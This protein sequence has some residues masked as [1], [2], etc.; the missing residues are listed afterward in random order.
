MQGGN[1]VRFG[2]FALG[3]IVWSVLCSAPMLNLLDGEVIPAAIGTAVM[4]LGYLL[5]G[6]LV[7]RFRRWPVPTKRQS[8]IAVMLPTGIAWLWA[9]TTAL[10]LST[11]VISVAAVLGL[12][13]FWLAS[14]SLLF[15][16]TFVPWLAEMLNMTGFVDTV[17]PLLGVG[18][19]FSGLLPPL[20]FWVGSWLY[21]VSKKTPE[22][23]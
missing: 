3:H 23:E 5:V 4:M 16:M 21:S 22:T 8:L 6:W 1:G 14:P 20:L 10:T 12:P 2:W 13:A 19:F 9:G 11:E 18:I 15:I 7:A 17:I